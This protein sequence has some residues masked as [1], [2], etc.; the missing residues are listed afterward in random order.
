ML[1]YIFLLFNFL[2]I[3]AISYSQNLVAGEYFFDQ[4]PGTGSGFSFNFDSKVEVQGNIE[5]D[6]S[7]LTPGVHFLFLRV[8]NT[9]GV[10]SH[11]EG[12]SFYILEKSTVPVFESQPSIVQGEWFVD[13]D[14]GTGKGTSF[15][16]SPTDTIVSS[17]DADISN[18]SEGFHQMFVRVKS[19]NGR[20]SLYEQRQ[21]YVVEKSTIPQLTTS[22]LKAYE[23]FVDK[24]PGNGKGNKFMFSERDT[25]S[26]F[27]DLSVLNLNDGTHKLFI[28]AQNTLNQWSL[29]EARN[30]MI[31]NTVL[32]NPEILSSTKSC[33]G[34]TISLTAKAVT[35]ANTYFWKGPNNF[36][37][38]GLTASI[39]N[40]A[41]NHAGVYTLYAVRDG[42]TACDTSSSEITISV[43]SV[44]RTTNQQTICQGDVYT[45]NGKKYS[46]SG[47]YIDTLL[48]KNGCD[49]IVTTQLKVNE[50]S[51]FKEVKHICEGGSYKGYSKTGVYTQ[52][53]LN[54]VGCDSIYSLD[55]TVHTSDTIKLNKQICSGS[56]YKGKSTTGKYY[57]NYKSKYGC[58]SIEQVDLL[59]SRIDTNKVSKSICQGETYEG[60]KQTGNYYVVKKSKNGCDSIVNLSLTVNS[61]PKVT[62]D[63]FP[64]ICDSVKFI[65]LKG[66]MPVGGVYAGKNVLKDTFQTNNSIGST[67]VTYE[68]TDAQGCKSSASQELVVIKCKTTSITNLV[69]I[70]TNIFPNPTTGIVNIQFMNNNTPEKYTLKVTDVVGKELLN[71]KLHD[72][73]TEIDL[74]KVSVEGVYLFHIYDSKGELIH[75]NRIVYSN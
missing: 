75:C 19:K 13:K 58:D 47:I 39:P 42:G 64:P 18:L 14:P 16:F 74:R 73:E 33:I 54:K 35:G 6:I 7:A 20:W 67:I 8:K 45:I 71:T 3:S 34:S 23:W 60:Y 68:Y 70:K 40:A 62:L 41:L 52:K 65:F 63:S 43:L 4:D 44:Q 61:L 66:G 53:H 50:P 29:I 69:S 21:F 2:L 24:D 30:F 1:R 5:V 51:A 32:P 38:T 10:W 57:F 22:K 26:E 15:S 46:S 27:L 12:R 11:Y 36:T 72:L 49:S 28:R 59:V 9:S 48:S 17:F 56:D 55:L 37:A 31:C 25:I